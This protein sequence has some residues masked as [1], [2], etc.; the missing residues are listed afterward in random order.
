MQSGQSG[1]YVSGSEYTSGEDSYYSEVTLSS[2]SVID[3]ES[4]F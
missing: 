2:F 3:V 4:C 1:S